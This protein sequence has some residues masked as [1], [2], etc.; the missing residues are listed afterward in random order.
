M[1]VKFNRGKDLAYD[2]VEIT[3]TADPLSYV[4]FSAIEYQL[5]ELGARNDIT[6]EMVGVHH[7]VVYSFITAIPML[8]YMLIIL[9][10]VYHEMY[11]YEGHAN[12]SV[13]HHWMKEGMTE[14]SHYVPTPSFAHDA[15]TTFFVRITFLLRF[16]SLILHVC[17]MIVLS[18]LHVC[19]TVLVRWIICVY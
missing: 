15:N 13:H 3:A 2:T 17:Q 4:A 11:S 12:T 6:W 8:V 14:Y 19:F 9:L 5:Y 1:T 16:I 18:L 7:C 10:Q